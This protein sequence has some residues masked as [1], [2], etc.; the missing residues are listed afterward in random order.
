M[1]DLRVRQALGSGASLERL[2]ELVG[3]PRPA[4]I[5]DLLVAVTQPLRFDEPL[6]TSDGVALGGRHSVTLHRDGRF[7]YEGSFRAT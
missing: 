6:V 1:S 2:R 4:S 3:T 5:G 7:L